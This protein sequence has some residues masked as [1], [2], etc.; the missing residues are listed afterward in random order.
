MTKND[1]K[2]WLAGAKITEHSTEI[3]Q[4]GALMG[5][6]DDWNRAY[7][8]AKDQERLASGDRAAGD[9]SALTKLVTEG[10][11]LI[12]QIDASRT[13]WYV[14]GLQADVIKAISEAHPMPEVTWP[15]FDLPRPVYPDQPT[16]KQSEAYLTAVGVWEGAQEDHNQVHAGLMQA[17][18]GEVGKVK[19][20]RTYE[21]IARAFV[22]AEQNGEVVISA[23]DADSV[24]LIHKAIG[25]Y[26]FGKIMSA[27][28]KATV[29]P[30]EAPSESDFLFKVS[31]K[32]PASS[33]G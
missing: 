20:A 13:V 2:A 23:L 24:E 9:E 18:A 6:W 22:R 11:K 30:S 4:D 10:A 1:V 17:Y 8:R 26:S 14:R 7:N 5:R 32:T 31:G 27:I 12:E 25:D 21:R 29:E 28:E 16:E 33:E 19:D 15:R 3:I